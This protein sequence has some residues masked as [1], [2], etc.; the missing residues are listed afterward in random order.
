MGYSNAGRVWQRRVLIVLSLLVPMCGALGVYT[1]RIAPVL[2][3]DTELSL[4]LPQENLHSL[5]G[6]TLDPG[7]S[8]RLPEFFTPSAEAGWWQMQEWVYDLLRQRET[9]PVEMQSKEGL[10][11]K[12]LARVGRLSRAD[13]FERLWPIFLVSFLYL[14]SAFSIFQRHQSPPGT[15]L[16]FFFVACALY[17]TCAAPVVSRLGA[18][19]PLP[20]KVLIAVLHIAAAGLITLVH[21]AFVFPQPKSILQKHP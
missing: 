18:L 1:L 11:V 21:F 4:L 17:F 13:V 10:L 2:F 15:T 5:A 3:S 20:W 9:V 14:L 8:R 16:A 6:K 12:E 19:P 7:F